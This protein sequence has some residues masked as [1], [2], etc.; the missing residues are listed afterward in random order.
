M[1]LAT[2][3]VRDPQEGRIGIN[4][5]LHSHAASHKGVIDWEFPDVIRIASESPG[6]IVDALVTVPPGGNHVASLLDIAARDGTSTQAIRKAV[7]KAAEL[8]A[9]DKEVLWEDDG[10]SVRFLYGDDRHCEEL[11]Q[12][13]FKKL[14]DVAL[15]LLERAAPAHGLSEPLVF[16]VTPTVQG[17]EL[18]LD[19]SSRT[20]V[21]DEGG[22]TSTMHIGHDV[23]HDAEMHL[24]FLQTPLLVELA[25]AST[26]LSREK[27]LSLGG[28]VV[29]DSSG[30]S[31][32][33]WPSHIRARASE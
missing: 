1:Y 32:A 21:Q 28:L 22:M 33:A 27:I 2:H 7:A 19:S 12:V 24:K 8:A 14:A 17:L 9:R 15:R 18:A 31:L 11:P 25:V 29:R 6:D 5:F 30:S 4:A 23:A 3:R 26:T 20:R 16:L 10:V 13:E